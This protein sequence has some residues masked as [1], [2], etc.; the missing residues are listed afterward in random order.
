M[1]KT[2]SYTLYSN[3][4]NSAGE[5]VRIA[6]ALKEIDYN[7]V[8]VQ[9]IGWS[10]YR[11]INPQALLPTLEVDGQLLVQSTAILEFLEERH[12]QPALLPQD[13]VMRTH[14]RAFAQAVACE[15]HAIDILRTRKFM[16]DELAVSQTGIERWTDHWFH[17]GMEALEAFLDRRVVPWRYCYGDE[18]GWADVFLVPQLNKS[19]GRYFQDIS[20]YPLTEQ[21]YRRCIAHPAFAAAAPEQQP[22]YARARENI[23][24]RGR[25]V[26]PPERI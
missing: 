20:A 23:T 4:F 1:V 8:S 18:P 7:Y 11:K 16:H 2:A 17:L 14:A 5:R 13:A 25:D 12:P 24:I 21:V 15:M 26:T 9:D 10:A 3:A 19:V 6:L 22:D